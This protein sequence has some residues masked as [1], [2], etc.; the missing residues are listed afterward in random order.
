M[1]TGILKHLCWSLALSSAFATG[2]AN[3][4]DSDLESDSLFPIF[5]CSVDRSLEHSRAFFDSHYSF[6][7]AQ[8]I[9]PWPGV[10]GRFD[11][12]GIWV[13]N[14]R[15]TYA[16]VRQIEHSESP[17]Y[18]ALSVQFYSACTHEL[19][20]EGRRILN[21]RDWEKPEVSIYLRN[22]RLNGSRLRA[23]VRV[24]MSS[25]NLSDSTLELHIREP[26]TGTRDHFFMKKFE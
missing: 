25:E 20:A 7:R 2:V 22:Q 9:F 26:H 21:R 13:N 5:S 12:N 11:I 18:G 19:L 15:G 3:A 4:G 16:V 1:K 17:S 10:D 14:T 24:V 23:Y 8:G 6:I